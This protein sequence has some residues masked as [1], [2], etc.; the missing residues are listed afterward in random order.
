M[1]TNNLKLFFMTARQNRPRDDASLIDGE[2]SALSPTID[3][4]LAKADEVKSDALLTAQGQLEALK[5]IGREAL[6]R[7][8]AYLKGRLG[9]IERARELALQEERI[10]LTSDE[11]LFRTLRF[12]E[13]WTAIRGMTQ[14]EVDDL[15]THTADA[16]IR[17]ALRNAPLRI[18]RATKDAFPRATPAV[19]PEVVKRSRIAELHRVDPE[20]AA[21]VARADDVESFVTAAMAIALRIIFEAVPSLR[22][23]AQTASREFEF[24]SELATGRPVKKAAKV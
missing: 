4:F 6:A 14:A 16:E 3:A 13:I 10:T 17:E 19:S 22:P 18:V 21:A 11:K 20:R 2:E 24:A 23:E 7:L 1:V 15:Y 8:N 12:Q 9:P 5:K